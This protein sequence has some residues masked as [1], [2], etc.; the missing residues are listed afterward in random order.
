MQ[1]KKTIYLCIY[2]LIQYKKKN[3]WPDIEVNDIDITMENLVSLSNQDFG[4]EVAD[5]IDWF[6]NNEKNDDVER[7]SIKMMWELYE[8]E[9]KHVP[10]IRDSKK[11][12][13]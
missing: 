5:W 8:V 6:L 10:R 9:N 13:K 4:Y 12:N 2:D 11:K 3:L 7:E 1:N